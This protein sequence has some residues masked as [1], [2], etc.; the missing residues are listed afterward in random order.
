ML[1]NAARLNPF[2]ND[3]QL[4]YFGNAYFVAGHYEEALAY[5]KKAQE[6]NP[7]N[8]WAYFFPAAIYG[9]LGREEDA[10][11][12]AAEILRIDPEFSIKRDAKILPFEYINAL[13]KAGL[14]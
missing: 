11:K 9:H 12:T 13:H 7:D 14:K 3:W 6:R 2:P 1:K 8:M 4:L 10:R 5:C